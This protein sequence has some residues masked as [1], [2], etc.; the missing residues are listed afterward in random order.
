M[1]LP[2]LLMIL[3]LMMTP[4]A[5]SEETFRHQPTRH[6]RHTRYTH[7]VSTSKAK[8]WACDQQSTANEALGEI[9]EASLLETNKAPQMT[10]LL[11]SALVRG[12][13]RSQVTPACLF[14]P[15]VCTRV[16]MSSSVGSY[17]APPPL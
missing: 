17:S 14:P 8:V 4:T 5:G 16:C 2:M 12:P 9:N 11:K 1:F 7:T 10:G 6:T 13:K 3:L 15:C